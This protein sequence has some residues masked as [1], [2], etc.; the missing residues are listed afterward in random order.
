MGKRTPD[1]KY[2]FLL[3]KLLFYTFHLVQIS[4]ISNGPLAVSRVYWP[5]VECTGGESSVLV[6]SRVYWWWVECTGGE[7]SVLVVSRV[8]WPWVECTG[9]ESS[10]LVVSRVYWPLVE[11]TGRESSV[12]TPYSSICCTRCHSIPP[13]TRCST[14]GPS[15]TWRSSKSLGF[16]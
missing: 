16:L 4:M 5:W 9:G 2:I 12:R 3:T 1:F 7:S 14:R 6:V 13:Y 15:W 11:C 8:H 10:V